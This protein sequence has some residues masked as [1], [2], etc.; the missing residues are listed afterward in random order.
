MKSEA[1]YIGG[2]VVDGN[3]RLALRVAMVPSTRP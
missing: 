3:L 2:F 1:P